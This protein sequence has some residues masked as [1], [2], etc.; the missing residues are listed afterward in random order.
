ML[1][2]YTNA[3]KPDFV[4]VKLY[5]PVSWRMAKEGGGRMDRFQ[6]LGQDIGISQM[7]LGRR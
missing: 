3:A 1:T 6:R 4:P 5:D 2:F 7:L